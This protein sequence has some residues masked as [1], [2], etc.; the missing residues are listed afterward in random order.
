MSDSEKVDFKLPLLTANSYPR[1]KYD[2]KIILQVRGLWEIASGQEQPPVAPVKRRVRQEDEAKAEQEYQE[3]VIEYNTEFKERLKKDAKAR[4][5][6]T[7]SLDESH[8][9]MI[10][11][12]NSAAEMTTMF[13]Q[14][15][16][17]ASGRNIFAATQKFTDCKWKEGVSVMTFIAEVKSLAANIQALG[18]DVSESAIISKI[19]SSLP[20]SYDTV[21]ES[22]EVTS[23]AGGRLDFNSIAAQLMRHEERIR[24]RCNKNDMREDGSGFA[25]K[26]FKFSGKCHNC[27]KNGHKQEDCYRP[28]GGAFDPYYKSAPS[29]PIRRK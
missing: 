8:H 25:A 18:T 15:Y 24:E 23:L 16:G 17:H 13:G 2:M 4:E 22:L 11:S 9:Q 26:Q 5:V 28:G 27:G 14:M 19:I 7:R 1:W 21:R 6:I 3:K 12:A 10:R 29:Q 20:Q